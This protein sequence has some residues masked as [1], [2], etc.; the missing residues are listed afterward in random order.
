MVMLAALLVWFAYRGV[1][2]LVAKIRT[3]RRSLPLA[4]AQI[5]SWHPE[6]L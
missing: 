5:P 2:S 6:Q 3:A 1:A 4:P